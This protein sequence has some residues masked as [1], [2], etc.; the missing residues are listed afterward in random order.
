VI[1]NAYKGC[2]HRYRSSKAAR[3]CKGR[4]GACEVVKAVRML[5]K[6]K[7]EPNLGRKMIV[8]STE[9]DCKAARQE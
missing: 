6:S 5:L 7:R 4:E 9:S 2:E 1:V 8:E 3:A